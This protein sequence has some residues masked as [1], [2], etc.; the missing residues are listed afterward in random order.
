MHSMVFPTN[1]RVR[2]G[3][4]PTHW[5]VGEGIARP[6]AGQPPWQG[7]MQE[8]SAPFLSSPDWPSAVLLLCPGR[9]TRSNLIAT[10]P[11]RHFCREQILHADLTSLHRQQKKQDEQYVEPTNLHLC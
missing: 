4:M 10:H 3:A 6:D 9:K 11:D 5:G 1:K 8:M 2:S 7:R